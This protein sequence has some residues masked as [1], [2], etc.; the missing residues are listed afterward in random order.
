MSGANKR[1]R[2]YKKTKLGWL[3][4]DWRLLTVREI[5][6]RVT[7]GIASAATHAY[8]PQGVRMF[9]NMNIREG[10]ID[11]RSPL[12]LDPDY[13]KRH[14]RKRLRA[15]DIVTVRTGYPG[16]S[17]VVTD[18][19]AGAQVFT[20]LITTPNQHFVTADYLC[21]YINSPYGKRQFSQSEAGGAQKNVNAS[22]LSRLH[23]P[24]PPLPEQKNI[25]SILSAWD[26]AIEKTGDLVAAKRKQSK[27]LMRQVLTG[28][29]RLPGF[30][31]RWAPT[32]LSALVSRIKETADEPQKY[33]VLSITAGT[34][35]VS[36]A[37]KFSRVIAGKHIENY[38]LLR[39]GEFSYNKGNSYRYPQGC[40][41]QLHEYDEGLVPSV[42][43]SFRVKPKRVHDAF[44]KHY[45]IAGLHN[46]QL[47]RWINTGVRNN[48]LLNLN[49]SDFFNIQIDLP[50]LKEQRAIAAVLDTADREIAALEAKLKALQRQKKGLMQ[51]LLTGQ[52]RVKG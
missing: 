22:M 24:L 3:P 2:G 46:A 51:R 34:G 27:A 43:Y 28:K 49:A 50:D 14:R 6:S 44:L 20:S 30:A 7:V 47:Y 52:V 21:L 1:T 32:R 39:R 10:F 13:E 38:V 35:F 16:V 26:A 33:P 17:A 45:F 23:V 36:Q 12:F 19:H 42:F 29:R 25:A 9:R 11:D 41:Y 40:V 15:G 48:G 5:A 18:R 8:R 37:D 4:E 31:G